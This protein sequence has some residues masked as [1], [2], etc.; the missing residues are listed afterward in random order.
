MEQIPW[1]K[2]ESVTIVVLGNTGN[3]PHAVRSV[4]EWFNYRVDTIW[5]GSREEF[6]RV[7]QGD[8]TTADTLIISAHG[9]DGEILAPDEPNITIKDIGGGH[10]N[11]KTII[12]LGCTTGSEKMAE[13]FRQAGANHYIAP[14]D[15]IEG[16][17]TLVFVMHVFYELSMN[18]E[19]SIE[20]AVTK[21]K[22]FDEQSDIFALLF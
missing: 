1:I 8:I 12:N 18:K 14:S 20:S 10:V 15:Y 22:A 16:N 19:A 21:A 3:E 13:A 6:M 5:A 4:L 11:G 17:S 7:I 9:E 2:K